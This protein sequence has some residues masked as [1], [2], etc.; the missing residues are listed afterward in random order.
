MSSVVHART[1]H[2]LLEPWSG[3]SIVV[4]QGLDV[5]GAADRYLGMM[6][7]TLERFDRVD[8]RFSAAVALEQRLEA[9]PLVARTR[10]W[11][12]RGLLA[13]GAPRDAERAATLL[14]QCFET[15]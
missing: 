11:W 3:Q 10:Y 14:A 9:P 6:E 13:R 7:L 12:A 5:L 1:L 2:E 4:G 8:E 15:A